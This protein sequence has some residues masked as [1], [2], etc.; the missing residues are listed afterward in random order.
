MLQT[1]LLN[2]IERVRFISQTV[3]AG[4]LRLVAYNDANKL[5]IM[6]ARAVEPLVEL[7]ASANA[8]VKE[9]V[10]VSGPHIRSDL[11]IDWN[12]TGGR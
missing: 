11:I 12:I 5:S 1:N 9:Q 6:R 7:L 10:S 8:E 4:V 3:V 2:V